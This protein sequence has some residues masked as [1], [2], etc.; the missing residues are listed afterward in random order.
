MDHIEMKMLEFASEEDH[1]R[2]M[3]YALDCIIARLK[4][5]E[6]TVK[7]AH[8]KHARLNQQFGKEA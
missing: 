8:E 7:Q 4:S 1:H 2:R 6:I 5:G 3:A